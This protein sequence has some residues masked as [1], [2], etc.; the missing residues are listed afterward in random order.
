MDSGNLKTNP[1]RQNLN[2]TKRI[3]NEFQRTLFEQGQSNTTRKLNRKTIKDYASWELI[4]LT[5]RA[6]G[7]TETY[8]VQAIDV[9]LRSQKTYMKQIK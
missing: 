1:K 9:L 5:I 7:A 4:I 8:P 2:N 3:R 6:Q